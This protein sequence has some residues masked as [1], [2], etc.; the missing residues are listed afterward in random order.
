MA[1]LQDF[2]KMAWSFISSI[3]KTGWDFILINDQ[4]FSFRNVVANKLTLKLEKSTINRSSKDL[5]GKEVE[6]AKLPPPISICLPGEVLEKSKFFNKDNKSKKTTN[7]NV[8]KLYA[9]ATSSNI[10]DILKLKNN[11]PKLL[12]KKIKGIY[13]II[14]NKD[15]VKPWLNMTTKGPF[16]K[17]VIVLMSKFNINNILALANKHVTNIN[18]TLKNIK[19]NVTVNFIYLDNSG[20]TIVSNLIAS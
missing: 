3:Y 19:S 4:N 12:A 18:R 6:I 2:G 10:L 15:K 20:I 14:N 5:K 1:E 13:R 17:Q 9:Q 8:R 7:S 16:R 11:F